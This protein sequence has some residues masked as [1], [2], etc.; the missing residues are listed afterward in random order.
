M[1]NTVL[2]TGAHGFIG[3]HIARHLK[4]AGWTV[5]G[6]GHGQWSTDTCHE[7]GIDRWAASEVDLEGL[8]TNFGHECITH[9]VHCA[10]SGSVGFSFEYPLQDFERSV[11]TTIHVLEFART[12]S[13]PVKTI[14]LS[15]AG[16]YGHVA[17]LPI[18]E[19][20]DC[21]P[22]SPYGMHKKIAEELC[23][24]YATHFLL[25][26]S[27][28]RLFSV[29]GKGLRKQLQWD[30]C[31]KAKAGDRQFF[32]TGQ[33]VRDWIH[34][35]DVATLVE[36]LLVDKTRGYAV[37]NGGSGNGVKIQDI[38]N[39][40]FGYLNSPIQPEFTGKAKKGDPIGYVAD[41]HLAHALGW[42]PLVQLNDG[43]R[44]YADW[45]RMAP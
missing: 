29:Y 2:I 33:E 35:A 36:T 45:F 12:R 8:E 32:G 13:C 31:V 4:L 24:S 6:I 27:V 20:T 10:G 44:E 21:Q 18:K 42:K 26:V 15:T 5:L 28:V 25:D 23:Q 30:A 38:L 37:Y 34:V 19:S 3:R 43:V 17:S 16:V 40:L 1:S 39:L 22:V 14:F 9:I 41:V 7:W 11:S